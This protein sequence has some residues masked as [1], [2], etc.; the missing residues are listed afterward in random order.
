[1]TDL[2]H[3]AIAQRAFEI[4]QR[5]GCP[6][7]QDEANWNEAVEELRSEAETLQAA[8]AAGQTVAAE[9]APSAPDAAEGLIRETGPSEVPPPSRPT[10]TPPPAQ[11]EAPPPAQAEVPPPRPAEVPA[12]EARPKSTAKAAKAKEEDKPA[13]KSKSTKTTGTSRGK[14]TTKKK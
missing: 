10:E 4:W 8:A 13:P 11:A 6:D 1:M 14:T 12:E 9:Q 2:D 3:N 7:G 5:K